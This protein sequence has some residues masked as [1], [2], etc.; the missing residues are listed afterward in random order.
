MISVLWYIAIGIALAGEWNE[1]PVM[2]E[3]KQVA[4]DAVR[5]KGEI[6]MITGVQSAKVRTEQGLADAPVHIPLQIFV[7]LK[8]KTFSILE[9]H[10]SINSVCI[11]GYG[12]D[13][14]LIGAKS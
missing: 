12:D 9:F 10:P 14:N 11:I 4:L 7:N 5:A 2:C 6:P 8:T 13:F 1:K 3:Q